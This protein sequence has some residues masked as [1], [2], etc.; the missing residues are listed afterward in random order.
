MK[1]Q[2]DSMTVSDT[3]DKLIETKEGITCGCENPSLKIVCHIDG[4]DFYGY[5]YVCTCG[6][7]ISVKHKR[8]E[9]NYLY[10]D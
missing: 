5:Q 1:I 7:S 6:N 10:W 2:K 4:S 9:E 8:N 3:M